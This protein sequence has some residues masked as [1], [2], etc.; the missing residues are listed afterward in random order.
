[1]AVWESQLDKQFNNVAAEFG[2]L[3]KANQLS[4]LEFE[5]NIA[6]DLYHRGVVRNLIATKHF[7]AGTPLAK[8]QAFAKKYEMTSMPRM[9]KFID[10]YKQQYSNFS[11]LE[12]S[13]LRPDVDHI[14][15][16]I[17][18]KAHD[19][20]DRRA[21]M[22]NANREFDDFENEEMFGQN[23]GNQN[24]PA[25]KVRYEKDPAKKAR[26]DR[27]LER[28]EELMKTQEGRA[29]L[30]EN[31][32][33]N[34]ANQ[35]T[36]EQYG[37]PSLPFAQQGQAG[38]LKPKDWNSI[39]PQELA[40]IKERPRNEWF[41]AFDVPK[42]MGFEFNPK[43]LDPEYAA[44]Q[45]ARRGTTVYQGDFNKDG[46]RDIVEIDEEGDFRTIN[47]YS[48][49]PSKQALY[50]DYFDEVEAVGD[51]FGKPTY[52]TKYKDWYDEKAKKMSADERK[53]LNMSLAK[54]GMGK[55]KVKEASVAEQIESHL[56][57][58]GIFETCAQHVAGRANVDLKIVK[59]NFRIKSLASHIVRATLH[60]HFE[61]P[62]AESMKA[63]DALVSKL[64]RIV[65]SKKNSTLKTKFIETAK[66][67]CGSA[68]TI[69]A[70]AIDIWNNVVL[71]KNYA[72]A[73]TAIA[74]RIAKN[75]E[76]GQLS[77]A[78][79]N[80][81]NEDYRKRQA[82]IEEGRQWKTNPMLGK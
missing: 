59:K 51:E 20:K 58:S 53:T 14:E 22:L 42:A 64:S 63:E 41:K 33:V 25:A 49:R 80:E 75:Q 10:K 76:L 9:K 2:R 6:D 72:G 38:A 17:N 66:V 11:N 43:M 62:L 29:K 74:D 48:R 16:T 27:G 3:L 65:N 19:R 35:R 60:K 68:E 32:A 78:K 40:K 61:L 39:D 55:Y 18:Q 56:R 73:Q 52:P 21:N 37:D 26:Y 57:E 77:V 1:M 23:L 4:I 31:Y 79:L 12:M 47:G 44:W 54:A 67:Y 24:I 70:I 15:Q 34:A 28:F 30:K 81:S 71:D 82:T 36:R 69:K 13:N 45:G 5:Q 50:N 7:N 8:F 46:Y